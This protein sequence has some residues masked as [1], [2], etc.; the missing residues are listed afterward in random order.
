MVF[1]ISCLASSHN[2]MKGFKK[3]VQ[4]KNLKKDMCNVSC[5]TDT[6]ELVRTGITQ[7]PE[8]QE[9]WRIG[10]HFYVW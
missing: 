8:C 7:M 10:G 6:K 5:N 9:K 2:M 4:L 1:S 3:T